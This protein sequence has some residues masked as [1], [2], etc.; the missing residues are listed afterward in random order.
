VRDAEVLKTSRYGYASI[1]GEL[2]MSKGTLQAFRWTMVAILAALPCVRVILDPVSSVPGD[3][4]IYARVG[5]AVLSGQ[6]PYRDF[7]L[8]YPPGVIPM[9]ILPALVAAR[10]ADYA[11]LFAIEMTLLSGTSVLLVA[12]TARRLGRPWV[13]AALIYF[14]AGEWLL[15]LIT[16]R[17]DAVV[18]FALAGAAW[19]LAVRRHA[20]A[21][22]FLGFGMLAK[23]TPVL[24]VA[25]VYPLRGGRV[26]CM[27]AFAGIVLA[28][29]IA[30]LLASP[31]GLLGVFR[32]HAERGLQLESFASAVLLK[33]GLVEGIAYRYQALEVVGGWPEAATNAA[34]P[35][36]L[37]LLAVTA[38]V[39]WYR[40][41]RG[42]F[43]AESFA[44]CASAM[45]L[46]FMVGSK[47]LSPQYLIWLL[48]LVPLA[49][50]SIWPLLGASA[51]FLLSC[52][53]TIQVLPPLYGQNPALAE[54]SHAL[55]LGEIDLIEAGRY[56]SMVGSEPLY[57]FLPPL[58]VLLGRNVLL[59]VLWLIMLV[60]P[61]RAGPPARQRYSAGPSSGTEMIPQEPGLRGC[62]RRVGT[63]LW[64]WPRAVV[65]ATVVVL[66][67]ANIA[68]LWR[69][70]YGFPLDIDEAG[71]LSTALDNTAALESGGIVGLWDAFMRLTPQA[72]LIP[73]LTVPFHLLFGYGVFPG[74]LV[75]ECFFA[76]L[77]LSSYGIGRRL[78]TPAYGALTAV[79]VATVP[80]VTDFTR[81]YIFA[82][83]NAALVAAA[84][85]ALLASER[86]GRREWALLFG[87][88]LGLGLLA[89]TMTLGFVP[90][91]VA[92]AV[93]LVATASDRR[94]ARAAN[95]GLGLL[96]GLA[97]AAP[98]YVRNLSPVMDYL[99][100]Y[101]YGKQ[102]L[103]YGESH[104]LLS[105]G[106]WAFEINSAINNGLYVPLAAVLAASSAVGLL[107]VVRRRDG[108]L[109][110]VRAAGGH[111][112]FAVTVVVVAGYFALSSTS[113][114]GNAFAL[115]LLPLVVALGVALLWRVDWRPVQISLVAGLIAVSLLNAVMKAGLVPT[116]SAE[117]IVDV[118]LLGSLH[119]SDGR[120][121]IQSYMKNQGYEIGPAASPMPELHRR[122]LPV[123][124]EVA[125]FLGDFSAAHGRAPAPYFST[126]DPLFN[127]NT[128]RMAASLQRRPPLYSAQLPADVRGDRVAA[129]RKALS[130]PRYG[131]GLPNFLI[132]GD[133]AP[134]EYSPPIDPS[135]AEEAA[136]SLG[137]ELVKTVP[138]PDGREAR[139]W[140][141]ERGPDAPKA[142][143]TAA[144]GEG[145]AGWGTEEQGAAQNGEEGDARSGRRAYTLTELPPPQPVSVDY[146]LRNQFGQVK[147][148]DN[149]DLY[150][151]PPSG[152][153]FTVENER[154]PVSVEFTPS[155]LSHVPVEKTD[156]VTFEVRSG[157][158][159]VYRSHVLPSDPT[160]AVVLDLP[161]AR[162]EDELQLSF[163]TTAGPSGNRGYDWAIWR[164]VRIL[165]GEEE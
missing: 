140:W 26:R 43:G 55:Q 159:R 38:G 147:I 90:G 134:R 22:A 52:W 163:V 47:V 34:L 45:L 119:V 4:V 51:I 144:E 37:C 148:P 84:V 7:P 158:G 161:A 60:A 101:G 123:S 27:L 44:R 96:V 114:N 108:L 57:G 136:R 156:G 153:A 48:P 131:P 92:A 165:I 103:A 64:S 82:I 12:D 130:N 32:Y 120:G 16:G 98:W 33:L 11:A 102:S 67:A 146:G 157:G 54:A 17:Y 126:H 142:G 78:T 15:P 104:P 8:E 95:L 42:N 5:E 46:A 121:A 129:Y 10:E 74:F 94:G 128:L 14:A 116:L 61:D 20:L 115:P 117:R 124:G 1:V 109:D 150:A 87:A 83:D 139:V 81:H 162:T 77:V 105:W 91:L 70:R 40:A 151:H 89:R 125:S 19:S 113:N 110:F 133:P 3:V 80:M 135:D 85:F 13:L 143:T 66:V 112:A 6:V 79:A 154:R 149:G 73:L 75:Q 2:Y 24:A 25:G 137:F 68:W 127:A 39:I 164:D 138:L 36:T 58:D 65:A 88:L 62:L 28:G 21:G 106:F 118:P 69:F 145:A 152:A 93:L 97:V 50:R 30:A 132:T 59:L 86:L 71:Y 9:F 155:F 99:L 31:P 53:A 56:L 111:E 41:G 29:F 76:L 35:I 160:S 100:G 63:S 49:F 141:L 122:W 72:P 107:A 23:L 18:A